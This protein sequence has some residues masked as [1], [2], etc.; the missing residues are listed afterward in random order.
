MVR[1]SYNTQEWDSPPGLKKHTSPCQLTPFL[2]QRCFSPQSANEEESQLSSRPDLILTNEQRIRS[3]ALI[4]AKPHPS[5]TMPL[6][7]MYGGA[8]LIIFFVY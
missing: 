8:H 2:R 4:V 5:K 3:R 1:G 6:T 7:L